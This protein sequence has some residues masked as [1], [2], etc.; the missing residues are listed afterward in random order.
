MYLVSNGCLPPN[1]CPV[2]AP[3]SQ[4]WLAKCPSKNRAVQIGQYKYYAWIVLEYIRDYNLEL[5][6]IKYISVLV[7]A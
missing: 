7:C 1:W 5:Y 6:K 2:F 4:W 3:S